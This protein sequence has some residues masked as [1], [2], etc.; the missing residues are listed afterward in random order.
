MLTKDVK[1]VQSEGIPG[2]GIPEQAFVKNVHRRSFRPSPHSPPF[3]SL[4]FPL[5]RA[6]LSERLEQ[7][8]S[9]RSIKGYTFM[10]MLTG[11]SV[12]CVVNHQAVPAI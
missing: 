5:R 1:I 2:S 10:R 12:M 9:H 4:A 3:F 6:P 8:N 11:T 7:A